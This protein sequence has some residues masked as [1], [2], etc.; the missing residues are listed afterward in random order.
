MRVPGD[1]VFSAGAVLLAVFAARL[2][3][4]RR[5]RAMGAA[6]PVPAGGVAE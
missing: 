4:S 3:L 5:R 2:V 6:A 1:I